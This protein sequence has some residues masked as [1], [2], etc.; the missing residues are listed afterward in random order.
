MWFNVQIQ[1]I[2]WG[3]LV[4][5]SRGVLP[6]PYPFRHNDRIH[7]LQLDQLFRTK[8][9]ITTTNYEMAES[10]VIMNYDETFCEILSDSSTFSEIYDTFSEVSGAS[11]RR[12]N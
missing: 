11:R 6:A 10:P 2:P 4:R 12:L 1:P 3:T 9:I 8:T 7:N 5:G